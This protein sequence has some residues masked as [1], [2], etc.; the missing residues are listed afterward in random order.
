MRNE[1][2]IQADRVDAAKAAAPYVHPRLANLQVG[3]SIGTHDLSGLSSEQLRTLEE[4][5][6]HVVERADPNTIDDVSYSRT[7]E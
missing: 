3:G 6:I 7:D 1:G 2:N 5:L 4:L